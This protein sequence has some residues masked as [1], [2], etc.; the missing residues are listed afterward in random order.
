MT[1]SWYFHLFL[2]E[3]HCR[4]NQL[5][6]VDFSGICIMICG[7]TTSPFY[8]SFMCEENWYYGRL[9]IGQVW[10]FCIIALIVTL[11]VDSKWVNAVSYI[12]AG[13]STVPAMLHLLWYTTEESVHNF[14]IWPWLFGGTTYAVGAIIYALKIPE[15]CFPKTFDIWLQSHT[16]FHWMILFAAILHIWGSLRVFHER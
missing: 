7:S 14:Q 16:I 6:C 10:T 11:C 1:G 8:Y 9:Y 13:Y 5:Q 3:S 2:C 4:Y 15:R 12:I